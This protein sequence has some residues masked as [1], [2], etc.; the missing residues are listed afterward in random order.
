MVRCHGL[1]GTK[2]SS[3]AFSSMT[4]TGGRERVRT[5][6]T[7]AST[8]SLRRV[9][10]RSD[11]GSSSVG[12]KVNPSLKTS[13]GVDVVND[14]KLKQGDRVGLNQGTE[15]EVID[16]VDGTLIKVSD[17][18]DQEAVSCHA[19]SSMSVS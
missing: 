16:D 18:I 15:Y 8:V 5:A 9:A 6:A 4:N 7:T 10:I 1:T 11:G 13:K 3:R 14:F 17:D 12:T 2:S 19:Y